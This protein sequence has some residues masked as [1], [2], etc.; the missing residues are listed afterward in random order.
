M[1]V[2]SDSGY[3]NGGYGTGAPDYIFSAVFG[4]LPSPEH[5]EDTFIP[6]N[7]SSYSGTTPRGRKVYR[8]SPDIC[9]G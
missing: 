7:S 4:R 9:C 3:S 2:N 8:N 1:F 6:R 5:I